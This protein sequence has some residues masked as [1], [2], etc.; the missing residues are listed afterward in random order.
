MA[1]SS[2]KGLDRLLF[3]V[4]ERGSG[5]RRGSVGLEGVHWG[6]GRVLGVRVMG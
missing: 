1:S 4:V 5:G 2:S 6:V 3:R